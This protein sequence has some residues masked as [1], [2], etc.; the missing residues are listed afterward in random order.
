MAGFPNTRKLPAK[1]IDNENPTKISKSFQR[2]FS[3]IFRIQLFADRGKLRRD[4][5]N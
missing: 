2:F 4:S 5:I 1:I 3:I